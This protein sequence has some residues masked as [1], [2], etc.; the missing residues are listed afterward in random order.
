MSTFKIKTEHIIYHHNRD[1]V[2]DPRK[3]T[4]HTH[5][6][7]EFYMFL[8]GHAV[9]HVEGT[10]YDLRPGDVL[11]MR[12]AESHYVEP[13]VSMPYERIAIQFPLD[14]F[15]DFD[16]GNLLL[17]PFT[18]HPAGVRNRY[19]ASAFTKDLK[20]AYFD[21]LEEQSGERFL[22]PA[23]FGALTEISVAFDRAESPASPLETA[24]R[25]WIRYINEHLREPLSLKSLSTVFYVSES[26]LERRFKKATGASILQ[27][28][29]TK[30]LMKARS[31]LRQGARPT[32]VFRDVGFS[33]YSSFFRAYRKKFGTSPKKDAGE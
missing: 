16:P 10:A 11:I 19:P 17:K 28:I 8:G 1:E 18:E 5:E 4:N 33:D 20:A 24:E 23:L 30:R 31:L 27:Y 32:E 12:P 3:F 2:P 13:D 9:F 6:Q 21:R 26:S 25:E 29:S 7:A 15:R 22:L 14:L